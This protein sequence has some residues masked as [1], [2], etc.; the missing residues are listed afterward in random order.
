VAITGTPG[1][2]RALLVHPSDGGV[3]HPRQ[4]E[5]RTRPGHTAGCCRR[6]VTGSAV[7]AGPGSGTRLRL[8]QPGHYERR[9]VLHVAARSTA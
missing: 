7:T 4:D 6:P 2:R 9:V 5:R 3:H 8:P 1:R